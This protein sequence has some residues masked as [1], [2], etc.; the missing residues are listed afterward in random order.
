[1]KRPVFTLEVGDN[2][3]PVLSETQYNMPCTP[4]VIFNPE[5]EDTKE[6][7]K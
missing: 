6:G 2:G 1:M 7:K 3:E 5:T 4:P